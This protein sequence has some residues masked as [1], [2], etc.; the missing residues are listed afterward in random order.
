MILRISLLSLF[1]FFFSFLE[2]QDKIVLNNQDGVYV[3]YEL[4]KIESGSKKDTYLAVVKAENKNEYDV[5]YSIPLTKQSNGTSTIGLL[6]NIS[7]AQSSVRNSTGL[8][9]DNLNL[10]GHQTKLITNDNKALFLIP[11]GNFITSEKEFKTKK[12]VIPIITN[13]FLFSLKGIDKF[14]VAIDETIINGDWISNCGNVVMTLSMTK[15]EK[16]E[17]MIQQ[18]VNGKQFVWRKSTANSFEKINDKNATLSFNKQTNSFSY[19]TTDGVS[20]VWAKK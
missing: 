13:T 15:N 20:C 3:S 10:N 9:G 19:S 12:G 2:A 11:R 17:D 5:F 18:V 7:F 6:E 14:D 16:G 1:S 8:F 4:T